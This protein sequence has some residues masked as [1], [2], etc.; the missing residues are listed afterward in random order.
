MRLPALLALSITFSACATGARAQ[1][2][3]PGGSIDGSADT[4]ARDAA[5]T[6]A[7]DGA[8]HEAGGDGGA[9][10]D[11]QQA[12]AKAQAGDYKAARSLLAGLRRSASASIS[13]RAN[14]LFAWVALV[15][16][17][18]AAARAALPPAQQSTPEASFLAGVA[19]A[20]LGQGQEAWNKLSPFASS[21]PPMV[22]GARADR[23]AMML[24]VALADSAASLGKIPEALQAWQKYMDAAQPHERAYALRKAEAAV[25]PLSHQDALAEWE[26]ARG[27]LARAVLGPKAA[28]ALA[29]RGQAEEAR[30]ATEEATE[31]RKAF[32][33]VA[34]TSGSFWVGTGDPGRLGLSVPL[35]GAGQQLGLALTRGT[36]VALGAPTTAQDVAPVAVMVRDST[37]RGGPLTAASEL[38]RE[39]AVLGIVGLSDA[40][41]IDQMSRDGVPYLV[42]GGPNPGPQSTAFQLVHDTEA[43]ARALAQIARAR[44]VKFFA[45]LAP[46]TAA[47][48]R[49]AEAF[50]Q[51]VSALGGQVTAEVKYAPASTAFTKEVESLKR[52]RWEALFVP[53]SAEKLELIAPALAVADLWP[54]PLATIVAAQTEKKTKPTP[55]TPTRRNILLL[56]TAPGASQRL[57][58]R[59]GRYVQGALLAPGFHPDPEHAAGARFVGEFRTLYGRDPGASDAYG[60]DGIHLL[61]TCVERGARSRADVVRMLNGGGEFR[62]V[63][64]NIRFG[65]DH[66]RADP[67][68][69]YEVQEDRI[70]AL[71]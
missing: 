50:R 28:L 12:A 61:R 43:R 37:G 1:N 66:G 70:R 57:L 58:D 38:A 63:T 7:S 54:Q 21:G 69:I 14:V 40:A 62:G 55:G 36:V 8:A 19:E 34:S 23:L 10:A 45:I 9:E 15:E 20:A 71:P 46:E 49:T 48:Q 59:A 35:T 25:A 42:L 29:G 3:P 44:G 47:A 16:G 18:P 22:T 68:Q 5:P 32:D 11:L 4:R 53:D 24:N 17:D 41:T 2:G 60:F 6:G 51:A 13:H 56:S 39:E 27:R 31:L 52:Q 64:G 67:A 65:G 30:K 26:R 33:A